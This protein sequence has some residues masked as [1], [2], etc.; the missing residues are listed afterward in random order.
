MVITLLTGSPSFLL[1]YIFILK[2]QTNLTAPLINTDRIHFSLLTL[3]IVHITP[4]IQ[5][6]QLILIPRPDFIE[7]V[8]IQQSKMFFIWLSTKLCLCFI[9]VLI[10]FITC[11]FYFVVSKISPN[12][13]GKHN[14]SSYLR[15]S[16]V[17]NPLE[18]VIH[19]EVLT[20]V[21]S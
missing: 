14:N 11:V 18:T 13:T 2:A 20:T 21:L 9:P 8:I 16:L 19:K 1:V 6:T 5:S 7:M 4:P 17:L 12:S 15:I 10:L 3:L